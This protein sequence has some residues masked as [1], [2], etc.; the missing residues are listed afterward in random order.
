MKL[1]AKGIYALRVLSY[2]A[3]NHGDR[4]VSLAQLARLQNLPPKY[5]EQIVAILKNRGLLVSVRG[6]NGGYSLRRPPE[7]IT[8]GDVIRAVDGP[9][10]PIPCASRTAPHDDPDC[11]FPVDVCWLRAIMVR[12]RDAVSEILDHETLAGVAKEAQ[13]QSKAYLHGG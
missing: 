6:K 8:L 12:V 7:Q 5:L 10:A 4:P 2:L 1:S 9:L 13:S 3:A 11:P